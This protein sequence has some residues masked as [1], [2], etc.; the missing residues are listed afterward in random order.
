MCIVFVCV[1]FVTNFGC[2]YN[3]SG[4]LKIEILILLRLARFQNLG[5]P[6]LLLLIYV[7]YHLSQN[8]FRLRRTRASRA[9]SGIQ[10]I[11]TTVR[12]DLVYKIPYRR[13]RLAEC[14]ARAKVSCI[15]GRTRWWGWCIRGGSSKV[16][17]AWNSGKA[18]NV[19]RRTCSSCIQK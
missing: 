5:T 2:H 11:S 7:V 1:Q 15:Q 9:N 18:P 16:K 12:K 17:R 8:I 6:C 14:V 4:L 19:V 10:R 13:A 3:Q